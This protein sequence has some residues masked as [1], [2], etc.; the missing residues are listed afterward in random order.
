M[1]VLRRVQKPS[2]A[3][4]DGAGPSG[5]TILYVEDNE[6]NFDVAKSILRKNFVV[7]WASTSDQAIS[8][9]ESNDYA[10]ILMDIELSGSAMSGLDLTQELRSGRFDREDR[11]LKDLPIIIVTAYTAAYRETEIL[12]LGANA[13]LFKP[14]EADLLVDR[15]LALS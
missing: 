4:V 2:K 7:D 5:P 1:A 10:L 3:S 9:L 11:P 15:A 13:M 12:D 8:K 14:I 6:A